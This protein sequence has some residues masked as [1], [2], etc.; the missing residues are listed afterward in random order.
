MSDTWI[1]SFLGGDVPQ[2]DG[3]AD[4]DSDG[5]E[6]F[7]LPRGKGRKGKSRKRSDQADNMSN[8]SHISTRTENSQRKSVDAKTSDRIMEHGE[9]ERNG[10]SNSLS[11]NV[12]PQKA[13]AIRTYSRRD[14][15]VL[16][17][18]KSPPLK[19]EEKAV[20]KD[21]KDMTVDEEVDKEKKEECKDEFRL[22]LSESS[23]S[24]DN[25][26]KEAN[27]G[28]KQNETV[29][30]KK[31]VSLKHVNISKRNTSSPRKDKGTS[32]ECST[33][34]I[35]KY[36][37]SPE[38]NSKH[39]R[40]PD[41]ESSSSVENSSGS[42]RTFDE[43]SPVKVI[44]HCSKQD[45]GF[46]R[47]RNLRKRKLTEVNK[48]ERENSQGMM[49]ITGQDTGLV[50]SLGVV[51][52]AMTDLRVPLNDVSYTPILSSKFDD[53]QRRLRKRRENSRENFTLINQRLSSPARK[54]RLSET[55]SPV[56]MRKNEKSPLSK[57]RSSPKKKEER[58]KKYG[59]LPVV[60]EKSPK[61]NLAA[62]NVV[63]DTASLIEAKR[64]PTDQ[65][66]ANRQ[67]QVEPRFYSSQISR[68]S[69][70]GTGR[71][72]SQ[73][74]ARVS[75]LFSS[76]AIATP[77][78]GG[79][80]ETSRSVSFSSRGLSLKSTERS[81]GKSYSEKGHALSLQRKG[82][83]R[84]LKLDT[85][86][87]SQSSTPKILSG[88][89]KRRKLSLT[90]K[91]EK[92]RPD[93]REEGGGERVVTSNENCEEHKSVREEKEDTTQQVGPSIESND[94]PLR[95][96]SKNYIS[97]S[98][99]H[100]DDII[101]IPS[102]PGDSDS[103]D[104]PPNR[105]SSPAAIAEST[106]FPTSTKMCDR[107]D[108]T[109]NASV[110][111]ESRRKVA[112]N[113]SDLQV[114]SHETF[115]PKEKDTE[116]LANALFNMS[117]PSPLPC[118]EECYSPPCPS[119][120]RDIKHDS[121]DLGNQ[122]N[123]LQEKECFSVNSSIVEDEEDKVT[124]IVEQERLPISSLS[125]VHQPTCLSP[126]DVRL[127]E[128]S[129]LL[130][131][132]PQLGDTQTHFENTEYSDANVS[133][134]LESESIE[135]EKSTDCFDKM[136]GNK[137]KSSESKV[138][139]DSSKTNISNLITNVEYPSMDGSIIK[140][141]TDANSYSEFASVE[142]KIQGQNIELNK[143]VAR[144]RTHLSQTSGTDKAELEEQ[145][146][147]ISDERE[148]VLKLSIA[149]DSLADHQPSIHSDQYISKMETC[150]E[151][152]NQA[153]EILSESLDDKIAPVLPKQ[154]GDQSKNQI[155]STQGW[156]SVPSRSYLEVDRNGRGGRKNVI[157]IEPLKRPP[158]SEELIKSL[159]DYELPQCRYQAPFC[160]NPDDIPACPR[161][162]TCFVP[163]LSRIYSDSIGSNKKKHP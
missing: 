67:S 119:S 93:R 103:N 74:R 85:E 40:R 131:M 83:K 80:K 155:C 73:S 129:S 154:P 33:S 91:M 124:N 116:L 37:Q 99:A 5:I 141:R 68:D 150:P 63:P 77:S 95:A 39:T 56:R 23:D 109:S 127:R 30:C 88:M 58:M 79:N 138:S 9:T 50:R 107:S 143:P 111:N 139:F 57:K 110:S 16:K 160:S 17:R 97:L 49:R 106:S 147:T 32:G 94:T 158:T 134:Q 20:K 78:A 82:L 117:F 61:K 148:F 118:V 72:S 121:S 126:A 34:V 62:D 64:L 36:F 163:L 156:L 15:S 81:R 146:S 1:G 92:S 28:S 89:E 115:S 22:V 132:G 11:M 87:G 157:A 136:P 128:K 75:G 98:T 123:V 27:L 137:G 51:S 52:E 130:Q 71:A 140:R 35:T 144:E 3:A 38:K 114:V 44:P 59:T 46:S 76:R 7:K 90:L 10:E 47:K 13:R 120:P 43:H 55:R 2:L 66:S 149:E 86:K 6:D 133:I 25:V 4:D 12:W 21:K 26:T 101:C 29:G 125:Q 151:V 112:D 104:E 48:K 135:T 102:S 113:L 24:E 18:R 42:S 45:G 41:E 122:H 31:N 162:V 8:K 60:I 54:E 84:K 53:A 69:H 19:E 105:V 100:S 161:L 108:D 142:D 145:I 153:R 159:N 96:D 152:E 70:L 65:S 14:M